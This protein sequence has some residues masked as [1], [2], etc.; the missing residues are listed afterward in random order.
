MSKIVYPQCFEIVGA[1]GLD[2]VPRVFK[3]GGGN[4]YYRILI[5]ATIK[6]E[7]RNFEVYDEDEDTIYVVPEWMIPTIIEKIEYQRMTKHWKPTIQFTGEQQET[8]RIIELL[9][10]KSGEYEQQNKVNSQRLEKKQ[11]EVF[12]YETLLSES[13]PLIKDEAIESERRRLTPLYKLRG[14]DMPEILKR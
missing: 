6:E 13:L 4:K 5:K 1:N 10:W 7:D 8:L 12:D 11:P 9:L 3:V 2:G 14:E